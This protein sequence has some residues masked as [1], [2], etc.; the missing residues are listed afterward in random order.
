[1]SVPR[2]LWKTVQLFTYYNKNIRIGTNLAGRYII[3]RFIKKGMNGMTQLTS[4]DIAY[5]TFLIKN[6]NIFSPTISLKNQQRISTRTPNLTIHFLYTRHSPM[7]TTATV[8]A[9]HAPISTSYSN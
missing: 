6:N 9:K 8:F 3:E 2:A 7:L 1:M 5:S 4:Y